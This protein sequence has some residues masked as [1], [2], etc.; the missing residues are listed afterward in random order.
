MRLGG[1]L[2]LGLALLVSSTAAFAF[3]WGS[4]AERPK[5]VNYLSVF[6]VATQRHQEVIGTGGVFNLTG[7]RNR[8]ELD[9]Q[10]SSGS[11]TASDLS[12]TWHLVLQ[13]PVGETITN[14]L[15]FDS[16]C[17]QVPTGRVYRI[18]MTVGAPVC[19]QDNPLWGWV[20]VRQIQF[21]QYGAPLRLELSFEQHLGSPSA[22]ALSGLAR[23]NAY[24]RYFRLSAPKSSPWGRIDE[25]NYD[26]MSY[27]GLLGEFGFFETG[28]SSTPTDTWQV[29]VRQAFD[30]GFPDNVK[31]PIAYER[32]S[33][34][35]MLMILRNGKRLTCPNPQDQQGWY[36]MRGSWTNHDHPVM[37]LW[38]D[39]EMRCSKNGPAIRGEF[40]VDV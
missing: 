14:G 16:N 38:A 19:S 21:D 23:I 2:G 40:R 24:E 1:K 32:D 36:R 35:A 9:V 22:P 20:T 34:H 30:R 18:E 10:V 27:N 4:D 39:F 3:H 37:G 12:P 33:T 11:T 6:D 29:T 8:V 31:M 28:T 15:H 26:D 13:A 7:D 5:P 17:P 25:A